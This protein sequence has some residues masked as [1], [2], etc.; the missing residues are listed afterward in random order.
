MIL[1]R[2]NTKSKF[3]LS[4]NT[5]KKLVSV[6]FLLLFIGF[7]SVYSQ[8]NIGVKAGLNLNDKYFEIEQAYN[9]TLSPAP[10]RIKLGY[11][12]G[13]N[14]SYELNNSF[15]LT[16]GILYINKGSSIDVQ[17]FYGR[18]RSSWDRSTWKVE[19]HSRVNYNYLELPLQ[20]SFTVWKGLRIFGGPYA[21]FGISGRS[22]DDFTIYRDGI[23]DT[24]YKRN[25]SIKPT[26]K[27]ETLD[28]P[29]TEDGTLL[30]EYIPPKFNGFDYGFNLGIG[31][32]F[33]NLLLSSEYSVGLGNV[34]PRYTNFPR[35]T[36]RHRVLY[37]SVGYLIFKQ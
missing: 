33:G 7:S 15:S 35:D 19:G 5:M 18:P 37:F 34:T 28:F 10:T 32:Q 4:F 13:F 12:F 16:S 8:I 27:K 30:I 11:H 20:L 26:Y 23:L 25:E 17:E 2:G 1:G 31:Y 9:V 22:N 29:S 6:T 24:E 36:H 14:V 3:T 21:A